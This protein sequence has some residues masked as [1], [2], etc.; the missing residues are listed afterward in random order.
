MSIKEIHWTRGDVEL[1][2]DVD[3]KALVP[4]LR[5]TALDCILVGDSPWAVAFDGAFM[6]VTN[7]V[8]NFMSKIDIATNTVV[9][10]VDISPPGRAAESNSAG[11]AFDGTFIWVAMGNIHT[12]C[13][14]DIAANMVVAWVVGLGLNPSHLVFDGAFIWVANYGSN[15]VCKIDIATSNVV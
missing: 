13:K 12:V 2:L 10:K 1:I 3:P 7:G 6:W 5:Q 11:V 14:I 15:T 8:S 9:A 4:L